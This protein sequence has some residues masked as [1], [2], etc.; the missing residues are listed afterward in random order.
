MSESR[1]RRSFTVAQKAAVVRRHLAGREKVSD[2]ADELHVQ[3]GLIYLWLRQALEQV[4]RAFEAEGNARSARRTEDAKDRKIEQLQTKLVQ[5][6]EVI[7]ELLEE[8]VRAKK[9]IGEL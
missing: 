4:E 6:N 1:T 9:A 7:A 5:K 3:P 8:N 2:L